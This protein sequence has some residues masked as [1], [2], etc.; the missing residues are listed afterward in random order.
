M[1]RAPSCLLSWATPRGIFH[2]RGMERC[3]TEVGADALALSNFWLHAHIIYLCERRL[4]VPENWPVLPD[5]G[6][7]CLSRSCIIISLAY[8]LAFGFKVELRLM[9]HTI[10]VATTKGFSC[11]TLKF[12]WV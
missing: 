7:L 6:K 11:Q 2:E 10:S 4:L 8:L 5:S 3:E 9:A 1:R 12:L